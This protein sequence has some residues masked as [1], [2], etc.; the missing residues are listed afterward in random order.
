MGGSLSR[1]VWVLEERGRRGGRERR[2]MCVSREAPSAARNADDEYSF[3]AFMKIYRVEGGFDAFYTCCGPDVD[4]DIVDSFLFF[5]CASPS[6]ESSA[7]ASTRARLRS[8]SPSPIQNIFTRQ[9]NAALVAARNST[10]STCSL[11][12]SDQPSIKDISLQIRHERGLAG[13]RAG[14]YAS[15]ILTL[16]PAI[17]FA[18]DHIV[19][20]HLNP[21]APS[22][23]CNQNHQR[24]SSANVNIR[25]GGYALTNA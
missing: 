17:T 2:R 12:D 1:K 3:D 16:N 11:K 14:Y 8:S 25:S 9:Q 6:S 10:S 19:K 4:K 23:I 20:R 13:F 21:T 5:P 15:F 22:N 18:T 24:L 7:S